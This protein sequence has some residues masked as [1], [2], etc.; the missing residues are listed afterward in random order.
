MAYDD[1]RILYGSVPSYF[2]P[3]GSIPV[4]Q[5]TIVAK[6]LKLSQFVVFHRG[7]PPRGV[8]PR[9]GRIEPDGGSNGAS[10]AKPG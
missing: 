4:Q 5:T 7:L 8:R 10:A 6:L 9:F 2:F 3:T 1:R